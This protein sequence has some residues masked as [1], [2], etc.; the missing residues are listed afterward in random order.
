MK[1]ILIAPSQ[2]PVA[3]IGFLFILI[4]AI[5]MPISLAMNL[6][7]VKFLHRTSFIDFSSLLNHPGL[8]NRFEI[9]DLNWSVT[10]L[11]LIIIIVFS[12]I[13]ILSAVYA[14]ATGQRFKKLW[15][16]LSLLSAAALIANFL[17][18]RY[19]LSDFWEITP[20]D[21]WILALIGAMA[22]SI[23]SI[24]IGIVSRKKLIHSDTT[25]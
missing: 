8:E 23:G 11:L 18:L 15:I 24:T 20:Y 12:S 10:T 25:F 13:V 5:M 14:L 3:I 1:K 9:D 2:K 22:I 16:L 4:G 7:T 17:Y 21:G 19:V 6:Y